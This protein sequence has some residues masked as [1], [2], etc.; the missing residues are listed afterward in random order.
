MNSKFYVLV[1]C[2]KRR[3]LSTTFLFTYFLENIIIK[4]LFALEV[5]MFEILKFWISLFFWAIICHFRYPKQAIH[6]SQ[7]K[8]K[9][10]STILVL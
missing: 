6:I 5:N 1:L 2:G 10:R 3:K 8:R 4:V 9:T 7:I